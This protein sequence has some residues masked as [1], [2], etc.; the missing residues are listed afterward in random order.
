MYAASLFTGAS[1][2]VTGYRIKTFKFRGE[3]NLVESHLEVKF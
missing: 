3:K 2:S 1:I